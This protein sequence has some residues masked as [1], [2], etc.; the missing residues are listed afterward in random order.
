MCTLQKVGSAWKINRHQSIYTSSPAIQCSRIVTS[1][2]CSNSPHTNKI[3]MMKKLQ[4]LI[5]MLIQVF[6]M[7]YRI[8]CPTQHSRDL[9]SRSLIEFMK[10]QSVRKRLLSDSEAYRAQLDGDR[11][12]CVVA[13]RDL[14][15]HFICAARDT[16]NHSYSDR[17]TIFSGDLDNYTAIVS[18]KPIQLAQLN[19]SSRLCQL[20]R[21]KPFGSV[22][23]EEA[24]TACSRQCL[25]LLAL[26]Y[27]SDYGAQVV[28]YAVARSL[29]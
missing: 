8:E 5:R 3:I 4:H 18:I 12:S 24:S 26:R 11:T 22:A 27:P 23:P 20:G 28:A 25:C 21:E 17:R 15:S 2:M 1:C 6:V 13:S 16:A 7:I 14:R 19:L 29:C 9:Y 10:N